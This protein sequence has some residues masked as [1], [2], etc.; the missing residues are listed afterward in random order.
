MGHSHWLA[1]CAGQRHLLGL[2]KA[3]CRA[4]PCLFL[5]TTQRSCLPGQSDKKEEIKQGFLG[6]QATSAH[7]LLC[8]P[9][10]VDS[11]RSQQAGP[12]G[13]RCP[14]PPQLI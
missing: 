14:H 9:G 2:V 6:L 7:A 10:Q 8:A 12:P 1:G 11:S 4:G 13:L 3:G 5:G